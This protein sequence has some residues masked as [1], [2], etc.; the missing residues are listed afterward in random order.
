MITAGIPVLLIFV[1]VDP[2]CLQGR[3]LGK[4]SQL[5]V[6]PWEESDGGMLLRDF[7]SLLG[8]L[9][10][11]AP[12]LMGTRAEGEGKPEEKDGCEG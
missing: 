8:A 5:G 11:P 6:L 1:L 4:N 10:P 3:V 9:Q 12:S 2:P 7:S